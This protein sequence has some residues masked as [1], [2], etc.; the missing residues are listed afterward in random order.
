VPRLVGIDLTQSI[1]GAVF[2]QP[3]RGIQGPDVDGGPGNVG[4]RVRVGDP[5]VS[6]PFRPVL[7]DRLAKKLILVIS[8]APSAVDME[9]DA[10]VSSILRRFEQG[11]EQAGVEV[12]YARELGIEH[13]RAVGK[14]T[15][16]FGD[17]R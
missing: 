15:V 14:D 3:R 6:L 7:G 4:G 12:G 8:G 17:C 1:A 13:G 11:S 2:G 9:R 5:S 10:V 16:I